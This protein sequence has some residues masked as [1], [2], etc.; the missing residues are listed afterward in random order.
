[1]ELKTIHQSVILPASPHAIYQGFIDA[2]THAAMTGGAATSDPKVGGKFTAWD[3]YIWGEFRE[4][5]PNERIVE[6]WQTSEWP[7][8]EPP[9]TL[10]LEFK[11]HPDGTE[12]TLTHDDVPAEQA[13]NYDQGW[14]DHYWTPMSEYF[15]KRA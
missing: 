11:S 8:D 14:H 12:L 3:G 15:G 4:L 6:L 7:D 2:K 9:S 13:D 5:V 1:M 10:T